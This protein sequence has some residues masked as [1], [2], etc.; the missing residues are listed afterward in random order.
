MVI[1]FMNKDI[2]KFRDFLKDDLR[3]KMDFTQTD[4]N[5][6]VQMPPVEKPFSND[7]KRIKLPGPDEWHSIKGLN[8]VNAIK[9]RK[10][11]RKYLDRPIELEELSFLL[12][13]T[14][15][16]RK[17][18]GQI[19]LRNVPSAGNR[20]AIDTYLCIMNV[21]D[22]DP[23]I[24][25]Y[26]PLEHELLVE[27]LVNNTSEFIERIGHAA[28][29]QFFIGTGAVVFIWVA[30]PYR[31]EWRYGIAAHKVIAIDAGHI[32]QNLYIACEVIESGTC[33]IAAYNQELM[34]KLVGVDGNEE[35]TIYLAPVGKV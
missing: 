7:R 12:W 35:F 26:L 20:H 2:E 15:G 16:V 4:Q 23:G 17:K 19:T 22:L 21:S 24:Y 13:A 18:L 9:N 32:C 10:S 1:Y 11:R 29:G 5:L 6:G 27:S 8:A 14:H 33:A 3:L 28:L 25:C 30:V 31:M 34:D